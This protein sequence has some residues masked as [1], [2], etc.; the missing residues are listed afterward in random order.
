MVVC[1]QPRPEAAAVSQK[2]CEELHN[3]CLDETKRCE[4]FLVPRRQ[5][6]AWK[7]LKG[8]ICRVSLVEGSQVFSM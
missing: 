7:L 6:R 4:E 2:L 5:G 1:Y 3:S 8:Q